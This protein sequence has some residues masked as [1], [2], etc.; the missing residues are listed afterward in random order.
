MIT[1]QYEVGG[2]GIFVRCIKFGF[3][4]ETIAIMT[5]CFKRFSTKCQSALIDLPISRPLRLNDDSTG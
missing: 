4:P 1:T 3:S 2:L 5:K